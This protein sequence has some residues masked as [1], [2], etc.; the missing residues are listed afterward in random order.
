MKTQNAVSLLANEIARPNWF[1]MKLNW[2][3]GLLICHTLDKPESIFSVHWPD[4]I[5][6]SEENLVRFWM[7]G[8]ITYVESLLKLLQKCH[9]DIKYRLWITLLRVTSRKTITIITSWQVNIT[10]YLVFKF[11]PNLEPPEESISVGTPFKILN[12][13][14][15]ILVSHKNCKWK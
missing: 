1:I 4:I 10:S 7:S 2:I 15:K 8:Q 9:I 11:L 5:Q 13:I 6:K 12:F 3:E 14:F